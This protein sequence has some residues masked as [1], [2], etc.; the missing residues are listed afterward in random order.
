MMHF[1]GCQSRPR[2]INALPYRTM[3]RTA[4]VPSHWAHA[5]TMFDVPVLG[6]SKQQPVDAERTSAKIEYVGNCASS[7]PAGGVDATTIRKGLGH[8]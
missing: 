3:K 6:S 8:T 4:E 1:A 7:V 5:G 2:R